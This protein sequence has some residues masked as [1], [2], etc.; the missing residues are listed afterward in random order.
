M[1]K[2]FGKD[3]NNQDLRDIHR[4]DLVT[5]HTGDWPPSDEH[6]V[7]MDMA[8]ITSV[9]YK[10]KTLNC[11]TFTTK[12]SLSN[13]EWASLMFDPETGNGVYT[14]PKPQ[15]VGIVIVIGNKGVF[16]L[17]NAIIDQKNGTGYSDLRE[18]VPPGSFVVKTSRETKQVVT[19]NL[20]YLQAAHFCKIVLQRISKQ[21]AVVFYKLRMKTLGGFFDWISD[22]LKNE[23]YI[24]MG[25]GTTLGGQKDQDG[26]AVPPGGTWISM[27]AGTSDDAVVK[28]EVGPKTDGGDPLEESTV[29][30]LRA[31]VKGEFEKKKPPVRTREEL[32]RRSTGDNAD[33][34]D[35]FDAFFSFTQ[36][37]DLTV[38]LMVES[39]VDA[40]SFV[41][42][43]QADG[44]G[45]VKRL[46]PTEDSIEF[47][48][49]ADDGK[50]I[51]VPDDRRSGENVPAGEDVNL[52]DAS[53][54][55][56]DPN[57]EFLI[58][59]NPV[60]KKTALG[61]KLVEKARAGEVKED[62]PDW[63]DP[64]MASVAFGAYVE[65]KGQLT[66]EQEQG[67]DWS[68]EDLF[69]LRSTEG[70]VD[71]DAGSGFRVRVKDGQLFLGVRTAGITITK[72]EEVIITGKKI[73]HRAWRERSP[74]NARDTARAAE[75]HA[76][77]AAGIAAAVAALNAANQPIPAT[78]E[79][80]ASLF[81]ASEDSE[82]NQ[83]LDD[84]ASGPEK[85]TDNGTKVI[86]EP[87][88]IRVECG[89]EI[90]LRAPVLTQ[91]NEDR[92]PQDRQT[93]DSVRED[94]L[95]KAGIQG[96]P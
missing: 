30:A 69:A 38:S 28:L 14:T 40:A 75:L 54:I 55:R 49:G 46:A 68:L 5:P 10:T 56:I 35:L 34:K 85:I 89:E 83:L 93:V 11:R 36:S 63:P 53:N 12:L 70:P 74:L 23:S 62:H 39:V 18:E 16:L 76:K 32:V 31:L 72:D 59:A 50:I 91:T 79:P 4:R 60:E 33:C 80:D 8:Y 43:A 22:P 58:P 51:P 3:R 2:L 6:R 81:D 67:V 90:S 44:V 27:F 57:F 92:P 1:G 52:L 88:L 65:E 95:S 37:Q 73:T 17:H 41:D 64:Y 82:L 7:V 96:L 66:I 13:I 19:P 77:K 25:I 15:M 24:K 47:I 9:D 94:L 26:N 87:D 42:Q 78:V 20:T 86:I 45:G 29:V 71:I 84:Q 48:G 21:I 61:K